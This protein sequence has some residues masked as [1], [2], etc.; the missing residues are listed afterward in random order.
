MDEKFDAIDNQLNIATID[1]RKVELNKCF[2]SVEGQQKINGIVKDC[3][4]VLRRISCDRVESTSIAVS[5][6]PTLMVNAI[7][8]HTFFINQIESIHLVF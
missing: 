2:K 5:S 8:A 4:I 6:S 1:R 3:R 7:Q